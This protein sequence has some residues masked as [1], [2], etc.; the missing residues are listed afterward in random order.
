[1]SHELILI[2]REYPESLI[3]DINAAK[4]TIDM[5]TYIFASDEMGESIANALIDAAKRK[6]KVRLLVDGVGTMNWKNNLSYKIEAAGVFTKVYHP[7][8]FLFHQ[9]HNSSSFL[10]EIAH[11]F[12]H[13]NSRNHRK[14]CLI[15]KKI[16]YV[17]SANII[18]NAYV[19][20]QKILW[21]DIGIRLTEINTEEIQ[22]A[23]NK[24][25]GCISFTKRLQ[26]FFIK[27]NQDPIFR[28][29]YS[30]KKRRFLYR[31][32]ANKIANSNKRIWIAN[33]Y[34]FPKKF[35]LNRL[36]QAA[37]R[38]IDVR[39]IVPE[40]TDIIGMPI[41]SKYYYPIL[42]KKGVTIMHHTDGM[43]HA[44]ISIIDDWFCIGSSNFNHRSLRRDLEADVTIQNQETKKKL[45]DYFQNLFENSVKVTSKEDV[46]LSFFNRVLLNLLWLIRSWY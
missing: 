38:G 16:V 30:W 43:L 7:L 25:W 32:L 4:D 45:E 46:S 36:I 17:G 21:H 22:Y 42:L 44:K 11:L 41:L 27:T 9:W 39:I 28:L 33:A 1:M 5:E 8:F 34:F 40:K 14:T 18:D 37:E 20:D 12:T 35:L 3:A 24:A 6:V 10:K 2:D 29:N 31:D 23:F 26:K 13:I 15:D 19:K